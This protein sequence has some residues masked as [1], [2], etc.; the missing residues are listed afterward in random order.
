MSVEL[1]QNIAL[2]ALAIYQ[3]QG[4]NDP[5]AF[6]TLKKYSSGIRNRH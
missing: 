5:D 1:P 6:L 2:D 4:F 3:E